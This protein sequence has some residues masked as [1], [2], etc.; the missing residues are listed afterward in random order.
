MLIVAVLVCLVSSVWAGYEAR[1]LVD[2]RRERKR[3]RLYLERA[4]QDW[5]MKDIPG[6]TNQQ[7]RNRLIEHMNRRNSPTARGGSGGSGVAGGTFSG[8][9]GS[10][11]R[12]VRS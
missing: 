6:E 10:G 5:G 12:G 3:D 2:R 7:K 9:G 4:S 1:G 8:A 11:G